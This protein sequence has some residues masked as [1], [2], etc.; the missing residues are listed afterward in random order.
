MYMA[1][2]QPI[3]LVFILSL[4]W[5][6]LVWCGRVFVWKGWL[7]GPDVLCGSVLVWYDCWYW[8]W[9][10]ILS[11]CRVPVGL[12]TLL[13]PVNREPVTWNEKTRTMVKSYRGLHDN[14]CLEISCKVKTHSLQRKYKLSNQNAVQIQP[15]NQKSR[16][17]FN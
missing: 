14:C 3:K 8:F 9:N 4:T 17:I 15:A 11:D 7:T 5:L 1:I 13:P 2:N 12:T 6:R 16:L 10:C